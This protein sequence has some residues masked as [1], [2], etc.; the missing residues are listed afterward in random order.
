MIAFD[1]AHRAVHY[2]EER[3]FRIWIKPAILW[4]IVIAVI[5]P[6]AI[7]WL[8]Y[9]LFGLPHIAPVLQYNPPSPTAPHGFPLAIRYTHFFNFLFLTMLIRSGISILMDHPRLYFNDHCTPGS[10]WFRFTPLKVPKDRFWTAKDDQ[11]RSGHPPRT[12]KMGEPTRTTFS[13]LFI[14]ECSLTQCPIL[15]RVK[16]RISVPSSSGSPL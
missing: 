9:T 11:Q 14:G 6:F 16:F 15:I 7:A 5:I 2:P 8:Q 12:V 3:R 10:E 13:P 1:A 4:G